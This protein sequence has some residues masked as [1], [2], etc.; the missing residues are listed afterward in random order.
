MTTNEPTTEELAQWL[1]GGARA[2]KN[3]EG[4][5]GLSGFAE[6]FSRSAKRLREQAAT[7][8]KLDG[9]IDKENILRDTVQ[10]ARRIIDTLECDRERL[11]W[12]LDGNA[13]LV[14]IPLSSPNQFISDELLTSRQ[15]IDE[16]MGKN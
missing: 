16:A 12:L 6:N 4:I 11:D 10:E 3:W 2:A 15:A 8:A 7:I 5:E 1:E 14:E 13:L 9:Q